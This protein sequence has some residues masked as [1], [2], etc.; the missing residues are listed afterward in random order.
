MNLRKTKMLKSL[1]PALAALVFLLLTLSQGYAQKAPPGQEKEKLSPGQLLRKDFLEGRKAAAEN[2]QATLEATM[3]EGMEMEMNMPDPGGVPHYFGP[4]ANWAYSPLPRGG[5]AEIVLEDGGSGYSNPTVMI[6]D[7][8]ATGSGATASAT[9]AD[10]VITGITVDLPGT[11]Y[12]AP[13]VIIVDDTGVD[14]AA[15][16]MIGGTLEG[17]IRKFVDSLPLIDA[18]NNLG[19]Y[20]PKAVPDTTTY[21][22][23]D[24]Y[25]I[26]LVQYTEKMHSDLPPTLLRGYVQEKDG[27]Q[28]GIPHY[29]GPVIIA[30]RDKPVR[31]KFTNRLPLGSAGNLFIPV[32]STIMGSGK[33]PLLSGN[34]GM[35]DLLSVQNPECTVVDGEKPYGCYTDNRASVHLH[36]N[37]TVWIS[38]GTP[39][40]W[41]TPADETGAYPKGVSAVNVPDM[42]DPGD[43]SMTFYYTNAHSARLMFYHDHAYGITR[44]NVLA[45]QA[46]AYLVTDEVER[47]MIA[48]TNETGVN[49]TGLSVLPG[50]GIPLV[51][52]DKTFVDEATIG[53]QDPTWTWGSTPGTA[54]TGDIW[55]PH[56][57]MPVQNPGD[58][59]GWNTFGRW[60]YGPWFHPPTVDV[61]PGPVP[62]PY[63]DGIN[64][65]EPE[66]IP[67]VPNVSMGMESFFD[68]PLVNGTVY[69]YLE[70]EPRAYR[71]RVLNAA[72]DRFFNL[73]LYLAYDPATDQTGTGTEVKMVES[74]ICPPCEENGLV[75][76]DNWPIDGREGGVPDPRTVGPPMIQIG[77]EGGFLPAPV[78]LPNQPIA[79]NLDVTTF[80]AGN[81]ESGTL[82]LGTAERADVIIDF[83]QFAGQTLILYNDSPAPWPAGDPLFDYYTG[84]P[85][86]LTDNGGA[87][88][89]QPGYGPNIR[90]I[91]QFR[92][93]EQATTPT[94]GVTLANL[95]AVFAK[96]ADK[97]GVFEVSQDTILIPDA[98]YNSAYG[99]SFPA[100]QNVN[101]FDSSKTFNPVVTTEDGYGLGDPATIFFEPKAIQD[102]MGETF[103][104]FGRMSGMLGL[105]LD[106]NA[107]NQ[108]F[109]TY[110]FPS[111]PVEL[112]QGIHAEDLDQI[113]LG[114]LED[115]TQ[116]WKIT[117]NGVDTHTIHV[118]LFNAQLVNRVAWDNSIRPPDPNELGWKETIRVNPLQDT[119]IAFRPVIPDV[120][121][122]DQVPN[123][124]R[125]I[126]P[127]LPEGA[128]LMQPPFGFF[129]PDG[130]PTI[131]IL[132]NEG[133]ILNHYVNFGWEYVYHC[134]LLSHEEMDMMH[135]MALA[136]PPNAPGSLTAAVVG[137]GSN[138]R[139]DL[140]W[141]DDSLNETAFIV[142]RA[143]FADGPW[144]PLTSLPADSTA[145]SDPIGNTNQLYYYRVYAV[146]TVGDTETSGFPT[147][148]ASSEPSN[149]ASVG[150]VQGQPPADPTNMTATAQAG[151]QVLLSW[152][153]NANNETGFVIERAVGAG[154]FTPLVTVGA[155]NGT[156]SVSYT[157]T[158]VTAGTSYTYRVAAVNSAGLSGYTS[159]DEVTVAGSPASPAPVTA[160]AQTQGNRNAR[161]T[162]TWNN[163]DNETGYTIQRAT[164]AA[165]TANVVTVTV[166]ADVTTY[167]T[168]NVARNTPFY[169]RVN[170]VNGAGASAWANASPFPVMTP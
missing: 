82:I 89:T 3:V 49:P 106:A 140:A 52:Q 161:V 12:S 149:V 141:S 43:G 24:Y 132:G 95:E 68:T 156:G 59:S 101:I 73:Q 26:A 47:D 108:V 109:I 114:V 9:V 29:M 107:P 64:E 48:G 112:L 25:E 72:N 17:G 74:S 167:T 13:Y 158:T 37:N 16:A 23:S 122:I 155:R 146:N 148:T 22:G 169:F 147:M 160:T 144:Q 35:G 88:T 51:I 93:A 34:H 100:D 87:P 127:T 38:D 168:G 15:R 97:R 91:M 21:P 142:E 120:P 137:N 71:F 81:V 30:E 54:N 86:D 5:V 36:G 65:W 78:L 2:F 105:Q 133:S 56:V 53:A 115:G 134:H 125:L 32:D 55:Y 14:A 1:L 75:M 170:A 6:M 67:G 136:V 46:A 33:G 123:S 61:M 11:G 31:V 139:V 18:P 126:D 45:G 129:E 28:I 162:L 151:P 104:E 44:L 10:G 79:W 77:T 131:D 92:V 103:D 111:P 90:T 130:T 84:N 163:V 66:L 124:V 70:V 143:A 159:S 60:Q 150:T 39:H 98:R 153:D 135:A 83:S 117:H 113:P 63:Y 94:P 8:Y 154:A 128:P 164:N 138:R 7:L 57:Y 157:D 40:Q 76:P 165:F 20:I 85:L 96:T 99:A 166:G 118:H 62:N 119:I 19:Q 27:V 50:L 58:P 42:P 102:E 116:I 110:P 121:F 152:S 41:I 145:Y 69:P 80:D 4:W